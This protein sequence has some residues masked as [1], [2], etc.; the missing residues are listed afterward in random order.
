MEEKQEPTLYAFY[1][2]L[3]GIRVSRVYAYDSED[4]QAEAD[5]QMSKP[6]RNTDNKEVTV[7]QIP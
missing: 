2:Y 1:V 5:R 4:A 7:K 6:G 3:N